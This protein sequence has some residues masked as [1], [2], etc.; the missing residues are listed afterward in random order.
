MMLTIFMKRIS[1]RCQ[2]I[3]YLLSLIAAINFLIAR[4]SHF[5]IDCKVQA[6]SAVSSICPQ[7]KGY[8]SSCMVD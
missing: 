5:N 6:L 8:F 2:M 7:G 4:E 1:Y 3:I